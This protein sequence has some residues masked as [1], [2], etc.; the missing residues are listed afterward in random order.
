MRH[1]SD[2][3]KGSFDID[4]LLQHRVVDT[5]V[6]ADP[7]AEGQADVD[8]EALKVSIR[9][10]IG[11]FLDVTHKLSDAV[12]RLKIDEWQVCLRCLPVEGSCGS[13]PSSLD[14]I[15]PWRSTQRENSLRLRDHAVE[16]PEA[17]TG[18][19]GRLVLDP[20]FLDGFE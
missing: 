12:G 19:Q 9:V 14:R 11:I 17:R 2:I 4:N 10:N 3:S 1:T 15:I 6:Q 7:I 18:D 8:G 16:C 20:E 5:A 13:F